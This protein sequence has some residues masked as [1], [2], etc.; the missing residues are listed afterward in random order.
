L[1]AGG[2]GVPAERAETAERFND[3]LAAALKQPGPFLV[4]AVI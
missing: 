2:M 3:L 1:L 4:E